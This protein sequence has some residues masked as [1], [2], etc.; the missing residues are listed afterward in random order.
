[1]KKCS[2]CGNK[3]PLTQ[4][5]RRTNTRDGLSSQCKDCLNR[6]AKERSNKK[7]EDLKYLVW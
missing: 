6:Y 2:K 5:N 7:K 4:F 1:M 3:K